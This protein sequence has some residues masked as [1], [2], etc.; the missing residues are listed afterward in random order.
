MSLKNLILRKFRSPYFV[1]EVKNSTYAAVIFSP[2]LFLAPLG[3]AVASEQVVDCPLRDQPYSIESPLMDIL[4][5]PKAVEIVNR[6]MDGVLAKF[7]ESFA[8]TKPPSLSAI[9]TLD[10]V[11]SMGG[12]PKAVLAPL[13]EELGALVLG[14]ADK[15]ARCARY[16]TV[17]PI[18]TLPEGKPRLLVFDKMNG[19]KDTPSVNAATATITLLAERNDWSLVTTA[20]GATFTPEIL[21]KFDAV[22]WNNISGDVL[23]ITQ[24]QAFKD[25]INNGGGFVGIHGSGGDPKYFWDWY[26]DELIGARFIGHTMNPQFQEARVVVENT[27]TGIGRGLP[28]EWSISDEWYSFKTSP[29]ERGATIIASLD[30]STYKQIGHGNQ[31]L[32][33][34]DHP[35]AWSQCLGNG[36]SFYSAIGHRPEVYTDPK[37]MKLLEQGITWAAGG[38]HTVCKNGKQVSQ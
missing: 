11:V 28:Q 37:N 35:I 34:G 25:Y 22:I 1:K 14:T 4:L 31:D 21:K 19:F 16:D 32:H 23:T 24:R 38:G 3:S 15:Q 17:P 30:E 5:N 26:V 7:P 33:M 20:N 8:S 27:K 18:L 2:L 36:R 10:T 12:H 13:D 6:H 9:I 29:R